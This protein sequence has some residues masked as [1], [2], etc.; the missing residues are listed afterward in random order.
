MH[1]PNANACA[2][3]NHCRDTIVSYIKFIVK[4]LARYSRCSGPHLVRDNI[5]Q[6]PS[7]FGSKL[8]R[9]TVAFLPN[10]DMSSFINVHDTPVAKYEQHAYKPFTCIIHRLTTVHIRV[11]HDCVA[12]VKIR[13]SEMPKLYRGSSAT[14]D[15]FER[16]YR[17]KAY[18]DLRTLPF[19]KRVTIFQTFVCHI[20]YG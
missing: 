6:V 3:Q 1:T 14:D 10:A 9:G 17:T 2:S 13:N 19:L 18:K 12:E 8:A 15:K 11:E 4:R 5:F 7:S 16:E 20:L